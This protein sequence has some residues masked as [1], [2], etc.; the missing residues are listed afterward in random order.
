KQGEDSRSIQ[1]VAST[2][3]AL[4]HLQSLPADG[5]DELCLSGLSADENTL[6][7]ALRVLKPN[8]K[9]VIENSIPSREAGQLL[10]TDL[11]ITGFLNSMV[12]KDPTTGYRFAVATKP[13]FNIGAAAKVNIAPASTKWKMNTMDLA[14]DDLVDEDDLLDDGLDTAKIAGGC[15]DVQVGQGGKKRACKNC[16]C[17]LAEEEANGVVASAPKTTEEKIV[18]SS[19]CGNCSKGDAFRCGGCP[20]LGKPAFQPGQE[21]VMLTGMDDDI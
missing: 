6:F 7:E 20:F 4:T 18:K 21:K 3:E 11:Q 9:L 5:C 2:A 8:S 16:S 13:D 10:D 1:V 17:G 19:A 12:A 15:G 14:E